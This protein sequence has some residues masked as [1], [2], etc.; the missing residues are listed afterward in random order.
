MNVRSDRRGFVLV[1]VLAVLGVVGVV[2]LGTVAEARLAVAATGH[3]TTA[4]RARWLARGCL[5][6]A[7]A[8][9]D[10]ALLAAGE[11]RARDRVWRDVG[12]VLSSAASLW[13][14]DCG[15]VAEPAGVRADVNALDSVGL[16]RLFEHTVG[17]ARAEELAAS[18]LDWRDLD[19]VP[20]GGGAEIDWYAAAG[21]FGPGDRAFESDGELSLVRGLSDSPELVALLTAEAGPTAILHAPEAVVRAVVGDDALVVEHVLSKRAA[22][23][24]VADLRDLLSSA[25]TA[26]D[27]R[28]ASAYGTLVARAVVEP[29]SW[30][31]TAHITDRATGLHVQVVHR[32]RRSLERVNVDAEEIQ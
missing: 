18:V 9:L 19:Q 2:T 16:V 8:A 3:R 28:A 26:I 5:A 14:S 4:T 11:G 21:R 23:V 13:T 22:L 7:R 25:D 31:L 1:S 10:E 17:T 30:Y 12:G 32:L 6:E 24:H 29:T 15:I 27:R 20:R